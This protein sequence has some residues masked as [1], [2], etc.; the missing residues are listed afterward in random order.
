[1]HA[2]A[3]A[4]RMAIRRNWWIAVVFGLWPVIDC[5][6]SKEALRK[7]RTVAM[8]RTRLG[9]HQPSHPSRRFD[10]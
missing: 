10:T 4:T 2:T 1:M 5:L 6:A 7:A 9:S 8:P 3:R